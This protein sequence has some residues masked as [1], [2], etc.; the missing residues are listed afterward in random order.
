MLEFKGL[1]SIKGSCSQL[2]SSQILAFVECGKRSQREQVCGSCFQVMLSLGLGL[3]VVCP[4]HIF[5]TNVVHCL[6]W[7]KQHI[8]SAISLRNSS[9]WRCSKIV[10]EGRNWSTCP[11]KWWCGADACSVRG[12]N[13][14]ASVTVPR[15]IWRSWL[16][17]RE[18]KK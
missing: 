5:Q 12:V 1:K 14:K 13:P 17:W 3:L 16:K 15:H 6:K 8:T 2:Y 11:W 4:Q 18:K 9:S 10:M 7:L